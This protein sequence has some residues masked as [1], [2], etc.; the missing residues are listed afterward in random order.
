MLEPV[1]QE[2][3]ISFEI[4]NQNTQLELNRLSEPTQQ[5]ETIAGK[6]VDQIYI[7]W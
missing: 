5:A 6:L 2:I 7:L 4:D 3:N 1:A